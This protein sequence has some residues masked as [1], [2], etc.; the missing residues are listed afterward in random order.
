MEEIAGFLIMRCERLLTACALTIKSSKSCIPQ[1][2]FILYS[3]QRGSSEVL[4]FECT[5]VSSGSYM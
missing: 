1:F 4:T 3:I 2:I 5:A